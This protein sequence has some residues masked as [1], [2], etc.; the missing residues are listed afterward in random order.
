MAFWNAPLDDD[1]H[2]AHA[3]GAALD[4]LKAVDMLNAELAAE[5]EASGS[6]PIHLA[7]GVGLN[8]GECVVGNMGSDI[9]FNY[10]VL[11]DPVNLAARLEG[12]T[13]SYGVP[14]LLGEQTARGA[15]GEFAV[16]ELDRVLVKGKTEPATVSTV[17]PDLDEEARAAHQSFLNDVYAGRPAEA[18]AQI[19]ELTVRLPVLAEY[20]G[21]MRERLGAASTR[22][23]GSA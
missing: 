3:V 15:A 1:H 5:A 7:I 2:A 18:R 10:S 9:R 19:D 20:Y 8:T 13:K 4:M 16:V 23:S 21:I 17:V 22:I 6:K 11:G 14:I 12:Q